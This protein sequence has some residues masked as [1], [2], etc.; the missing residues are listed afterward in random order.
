MPNQPGVRIRFQDAD[1]TVANVEAELPTLLIGPLYEVFDKES[2]DTGFDPLTAADQVYEWPGK[3]V[4]SIVDL[5]GTRNG[6]IDSQRKF[7]ASQIPSVYLVDGEVEYQVSDGNIDAISQSGFELKQEART[8]LERGT[9]DSFVLELNGEQLVYR[10]SGGLIDAQLGDRADIGAAPFTITSVSNTELRVFESLTPVLSTATRVEED[11]SSSDTVSIT[12]SSTSGRVVV[13]VTGTDL[14]TEVPALAVGDAAVTAYPMTGLTSITGA[15]NDGDGSYDEIDNLTFGVDVSLSDV[16]G[17]VV[18][19]VNATTSQT[20]FAKVVAIDTTAGT[21]GLDT[22]VGTADADVVAVTIMRS[23][24]GYVESIASD[25]LSAVIIVPQTFSDSQTFVDF[26]TTETDVVVYPDFDVKV[27][28][29]ALRSDLSDVANS[30]Q[31]V[32]DFLSYTGHASVSELDGLGFALQIALLAQPSG[33]AVYYIPVDLEPAGTDSG[34]PENYDLLTGYQNALESAESIP[35]Y[36]VVLLDRST[37]LDDAL[38]THIDSMSTVAENAYRR[39]YFYQD[40]PLGAVESST[41]EIRPGQVAGGV[42]GSLTSGNTVIRDANV[43]FIS[44]GEVVAGNQV[45]VTFP[46]ALAG[47]YTALGTTTDNDLI[48][49]GDPWDITREFAIAGTVDVNTAVAGQHTISG[50]AIDSSSF[51]FVEEGDVVEI[52]EGGTRYRLI[53]STVNSVSLVCTDEVPGDLDF[54]TGNSDNGS[55]FS[56]I[57]SYI[58]PSVEYYIRPLSKSQ[59]VAALVA[60]KS[61]VG[62][63][64]TLTLDNAPTI[65]IGGTPTVLSPSLT[66]VALAA[67]RSGLRSFDEVTNLRLGGGIESVRHGYGAF[68]KSQLK[69]LSD[70]GFTLIAQETS[71]SSPYVRDMITTDTANGIVKQ[72]ELVVANADWVG[73]TISLQ[74]G[75]PIGAKLPNITP[76]L[77]GIRAI[78]LDALLNKWLQEGRLTSYQIVKVEQDATNK[79]KTNLEI[80]GFFPV[81]EKEVEV[82]IERQV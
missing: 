29:R 80:R 8:D 9:F 45:V 40:V 24:V 19:V 36:N 54:G 43:D 57:R 66:L 15:I 31:E 5:T 30:N 51:L 44:E 73:K 3:R 74:F 75:T 4:G 77:L 27:S 61:L 42:A 18:K 72:E 25:N 82:T 68:K 50:G 7:M 62:E 79:R 69:T 14:A 11:E 76:R 20:T 28:Y 46:P 17:F 12:P 21:I 6:L 41:G 52:T 35:A 63:R 47:T 16:E 13:S 2:S 48:L 1:T 33:R 67:K 64:Y 32:S 55:S 70:A 59:Q 38:K 81:A 39:G 23:Q 71:T 65:T 78:Q 49:D 10:P 56:V 53:V 22:A 60:S 34:L 37:S 58:S 26:Y